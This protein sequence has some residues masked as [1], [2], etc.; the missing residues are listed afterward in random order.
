M[1]RNYTTKIK[2][3]NPIEKWA[4][5]PDRHFSKEDI[6]MTNRHMKRCSI[7]LN[8]MKMQI[9]TIE[10]PL[11]TCQ[12]GYYQKR[13]HILSVG[14]DVEKRKHLFSVGGNVNWCSHYGKEYGGSSEN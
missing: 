1:Q 4:E 11:H 8:I 2:K 9:K 10:I 3:K 7:S 6:Q 12:Y 5:N 13:Q 14:E